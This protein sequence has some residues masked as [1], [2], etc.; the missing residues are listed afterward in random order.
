MIGPNKKFDDLLKGIKPKRSGVQ[1]LESEEESQTPE[2]ENPLPNIASLDFTSEERLIEGIE[3]VEES[4]GE[5]LEPGPER[6]DYTAL[7]EAIEEANKKPRL[8]IYSPIAV[9]VL[10]YKAIKKDRYSMGSEPREIIEQA[11]RKA[12]PELYE[13]IQ[14]RMS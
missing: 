5:S 12:Y 13:E 6:L 9:A 2:S 10:M 11:L 1:N 4:K 8:D 3:A 14:K 7:K